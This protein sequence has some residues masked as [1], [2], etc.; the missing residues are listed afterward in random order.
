MLLFLRLASME[1]SSPQSKGDVNKNGNSCFT[2]QLWNILVGAKGSLLHSMLH[3][4][5]QVRIMLQK[6]AQNWV[7]HQEGWSSGPRPW[8]QVTVEGFQQMLMPGP[9][10]RTF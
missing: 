6:T 8:L 7:S 1:L 4:V 10:Q 3:R 2:K 9:H 5:A